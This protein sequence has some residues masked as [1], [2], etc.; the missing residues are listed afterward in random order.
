MN[1]AE[2]NFAKQMVS[3]AKSSG[4][5]FPG[6]AAAEAFLESAS[7]KSETGQSDLAF[8]DKDVFG[9]KAPS[10]WVGKIDPILTREVLHG[11]S[12]MVSANWPVFESYAECFAARLKVL[13]SS[14][15]YVEALE[16]QTGPEFVR[17]VSASWVKQGTLKDTTLYPQ[18][19]FPSGTWQFKA[20]RWS[21]DPHRASSVLATFNSHLDVFGD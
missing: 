7:Y 10:W 13:K 4:H 17:L 1:P 14:S 18:C 6:Y 9:L 15:Y 2:L 19:V 20:G 8:K 5:P 16:A 12:V 3:E 11:Q 21:T